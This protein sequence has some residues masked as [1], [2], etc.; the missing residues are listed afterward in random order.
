M[1]GAAPAVEERATLLHAHPPYTHL[2]AMRPGRA[3][4]PAA[5]FGSVFAMPLGAGRDEAADAS[6]LRLR[7]GLSGPL[8]ALVRPTTHHE[9]LRVA[10]RAGAL[11]LRAVLLEGEPIYEALRPALAD[12]AALHDQVSEWLALRG[13]PLSPRLQFLVREIFLRAPAHPELSTLLR[14]VGEPEGGARTRLRKKRL[15]VPH[16]WHQAAR[17]LHA[18]LR[19]QADGDRTVLEIALELGY[20][21]DSA[22]SRQLVT[23]FGLR[24]G[25]LRGTL[26]WE[27]LLER[28][29]ARAGYP[30]PSPTA[31]SGHAPA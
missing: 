11:W 27:W 9:T 12:P 19:I 18:T 23:V 7:A 26:G 2:H 14:A 15:P 25:Q 28:W 13:V 30:H 22:L 20:S 29:M 16:R 5:C 8:V 10:R 1:S 6:L 31:R 3:A 24:P 17:A 4:I 21:S